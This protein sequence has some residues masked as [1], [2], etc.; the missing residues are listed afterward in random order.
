[1]VRCSDAE[2]MA[3]LKKRKKPLKKKKSDDDD[4]S[5]E[6]DAMIERKIP[7]VIENV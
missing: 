2:L 1:M 5:D 3:S 4:D 7:K 6:D